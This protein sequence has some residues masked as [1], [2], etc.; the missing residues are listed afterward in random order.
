MPSWISHHGCWKAPFRNS[1]STP[2]WS[3]FCR[4][5]QQSVR[6]QVDPWSRWLLCHLHMHLCSKFQ[7]SPTL[8]SSVLTQPP[9]CRSLRSDKDSLPSLH[10]LLLVWT[11]SLHQSTANCVPSVSMPNLCTIDLTDFSSNFW[12]PKALEF[13]FNGFHREAPSVFWLYLNSSHC[14]SSLKVVTL[15]PNSQYH[16]VSTTCTTLH[17]PR[18]PS[19][20]SKPCHFRLR[21]G[22][23]FPLLLSLGTALDMKLHFTSGY[24]PEV[25]D[26]LN[27]IIRLW[28]ST[29]KSIA[30]TKQDNWSELLPLAEF[31]TIHSRAKSIQLIFARIRSLLLPHTPIE[32][33][34][35]PWSGLIIPN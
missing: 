25:T 9:P 23:R 10:A 26:K 8:C 30:T 20:M 11:S 17:S 15:H 13:H 7:Q 12:F 24:H 31:F 35:W 22:I 28:N 21:N 27:K 5:P 33:L 34:T 4:T 29:Y 18:F 1:V 6:P 16:H 32:L 19:M 3:H 14:W 2:R